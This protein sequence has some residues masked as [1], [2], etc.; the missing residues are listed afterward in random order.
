VEEKK[1]TV[2][3]I[4]AAVFVR[5]RRSVF[6]SV[7]FLLWQYIHELIPSIDGIH[8]GACRCCVGAISDADEA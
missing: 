6:F 1:G 2:F 3:R 5:P 4:M 8:R 7:A